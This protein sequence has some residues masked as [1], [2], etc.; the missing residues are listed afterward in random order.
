MFSWIRCPSAPGRGARGRA[1]ASRSRYWQYTV[2]SFIKDNPFGN[3][4]HDTDLAPCG[5]AGS[6][7]RSQLLRY[8]L[9]RLWQT[10]VKRVVRIEPAPVIA[11]CNQALGPDTDPF[12]ADV[13]GE[14]GELVADGCRRRTGV[15]CRRRQ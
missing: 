11:V 4:A 15:A 1:S 10:V 8:A 12:E 3:C 2:R 13:E 6:R 14:V 5:G 9:D 7:R